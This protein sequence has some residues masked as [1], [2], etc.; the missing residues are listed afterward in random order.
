MCGGSNSTTAMTDNNGNLKKQETY[1]PN[2]EQN[3]SSI[4]WWQRYDYDNLNRLTKVTELS[5]STALWQQAASA[6][7]AP[8]MA[9]RRRG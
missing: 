9:P 7:S 4:S 3:T 1:I 5:G 8:P 2:N 6:S